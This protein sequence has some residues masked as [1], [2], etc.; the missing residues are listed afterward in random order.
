MKPISNKNHKRFI[1]KN[2]QKYKGDINNIVSRSSWE[3]K[4]M[5]FFDMNRAVLTWSSEEIVVPYFF[6]LDGKMHRYYVDFYFTAYD[7]DKNL[8]KILVEVKPEAQTKPPI[9]PKRKTEKSMKNH[10]DA[11]VTYHKN[12]AKWEAATK[13]CKLNGIEFKIITEKHLKV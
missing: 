13:F 10:L 4:L 12:M 1:P 7:S 11:I 2:P 8:K 6:K 9:P 5:N 3:W